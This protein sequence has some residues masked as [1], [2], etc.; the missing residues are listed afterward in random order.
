MVD[1]YI[2]CLLFYYSVYSLVKGVLVMLIKLFVLDMVF[3]VCVNVIVF[4]VILLFECVL[5]K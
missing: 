2:D 3:D 4:G 5:M 1:M